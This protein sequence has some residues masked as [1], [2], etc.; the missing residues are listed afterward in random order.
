MLAGCNLRLDKFFISFQRRA[1]AFSIEARNTFLYTFPVPKE[2]KTDHQ[3]RI[4]GR[5]NAVKAKRH[6]RKAVLRNLAKLERL[7]GDLSAAA[8]CA[9]ELEVDLWQ[10]RGQRKLRPHGYSAELALGCRVSLSNPEISGVQDDSDKE[11]MG[12][13]LLYSV[14]DMQA[15]R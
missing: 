15:G 5:Q 6:I 2:R 7:E 14:I 10:K 4:G 3:E 12:V 8:E 9:A 13:E 11:T 1:P